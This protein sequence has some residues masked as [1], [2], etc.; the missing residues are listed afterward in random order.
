MDLILLE[1]GLGY[2]IFNIYLNTSTKI[3]LILQNI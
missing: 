2:F 3:L 1:L